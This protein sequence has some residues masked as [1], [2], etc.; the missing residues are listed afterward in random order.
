MNPGQC[1]EYDGSYA[2]G[3]SYDD[4]VEALE[5]EGN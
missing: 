2:D 4:Q 5:G 3:Y 1:P